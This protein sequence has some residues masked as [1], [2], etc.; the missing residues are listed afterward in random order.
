MNKRI[1]SLLLA[2]VITAAALPPA[3][4]L[5]DG[6]GEPLYENT[7]ELMDGFYYTNTIYH[8]ASGKRV[9]TFT[10]ETTPTGPVYPIVMAEDKIYASMDVDEMVKR[11]E[12]SF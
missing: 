5:G 2:V 6:L 1:F 3:L 10:L 12:M 8:N 4:A 7:R 11:L 9:E